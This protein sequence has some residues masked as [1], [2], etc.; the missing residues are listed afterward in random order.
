MV[1]YVGSVDAHGGAE[2]YNRPAEPAEVGHSNVSLLTSTESIVLVKTGWIQICLDLEKNI[3]ESMKIRWKF[4]PLA[5]VSGSKSQQ[6]PQRL[7]ILALIVFWWC[8]EK[9]QNLTVTR[10]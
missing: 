4:K 7:Q 2:I 9:Q 1:N 8:S 5:I 6:S 10:Y 3:P